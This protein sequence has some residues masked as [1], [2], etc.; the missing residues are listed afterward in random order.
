MLFRTYLV[1]AWLALAAFT[2]VVIAHHGMGLFPI[3]FGD[4]AAAGWPGQFD[5]DFMTMLA[6]SGLWCAWRGR[7]SAQAIAHGL[8]AFVGG[9]IVLMITLLVLHT[10]HNGDMRRVLLGDRAR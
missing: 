1:L 3:F 7:W 10:R 9:G 4:I 2:A 5:A 8:L 6:L